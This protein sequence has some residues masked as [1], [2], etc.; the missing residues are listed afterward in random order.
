[1]LYEVITITYALGWVNHWA[2]CGLREAAYAARELAFISDVV[3][4]EDNLT[5]MGFDS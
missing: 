1:M 3:A 4:Y 2:L 5:W